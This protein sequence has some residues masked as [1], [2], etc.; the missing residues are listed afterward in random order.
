MR[1]ISPIFGILV[2]SYVAGYSMLYLG[3]V[4]VVKM[5]QSEAIVAEQMTLDIIKIFFAPCIFVV[6]VH[7]STLFNEE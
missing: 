5:F 2:A 6:I 4:D 3:L 1:Y 7:L